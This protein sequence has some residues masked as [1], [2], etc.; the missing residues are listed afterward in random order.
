MPSPI[1]HVSVGLAVF[2]LLKEQAG[3]LIRHRWAKWILA[4]GLMAFSL[5][6]DLDSVLGFATGDLG[7]YHNNLT[8][9][10]FIGLAAAAVLGA[11]LSLTN[12]GALLKWFLLILLCYELHVLMDYFTYGRGIMA[13]WPFTSERFRSPVLLF[14]G[15]HWSDG[16]LTH[17][18][19]LTLLNEIVF[20]ALLFGGFWLRERRTSGWRT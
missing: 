14:Y 8:H 13:F 1:A 11:L 7:K 9:S 19:L 15:L 3:S 16:L 5:L 6:P 10:I 20:A 17:K 4:L 18:H 2:L 12:R